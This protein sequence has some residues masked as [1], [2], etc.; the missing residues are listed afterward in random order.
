MKRTNQEY[1]LLTVS[2]LS[3]VAI[4]PFAVYRFFQGDS[5]IGMVDFA[6]SLGMAII[7]V[8]IIR[9]HKVFLPSI[10]VVVFAALGSIASILI[11][12]VL[13]AFWIYP[14]IVAAYY[15]LSKKWALIFI[16][17]K[18]VIVFP[19]LFI[20]TELLPF[21]TIIVSTLLTSIFGYFFSKNIEEQHK[22]LTHLATKDSLTGDRK[23][24]V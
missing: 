23:S 17:L 13:S 7:F 12:G 18:I 11:N 1:L 14:V 3:S 5:I 9:T 20:N 10:T 22:Q 19:I 15:L 4:A 6:I 2:L 21:V 16:S 8:Y 24:V